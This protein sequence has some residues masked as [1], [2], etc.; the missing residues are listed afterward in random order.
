MPLPVTSFWA[1][2]CSLHPHT[3]KS[4][5][6]PTRPV[7]LCSF[8]FVHQYSSFSLLPGCPLSKKNSIEIGPVIVRKDWMADL[9]GIYLDQSTTA[10]I[11]V[12]R[13]TDWCRALSP[14][15]CSQCFIWISTFSP[16][17]N[18]WDGCYYYPHF[19]D[20]KTAKEECIIAPVS[21][22]SSGRIRIW[23]QVIWLQSQYAEVSLISL[24]S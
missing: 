11:L 8:L 10:W 13:P 20:M 12:R 15:H 18:L 17:S 6:T 7:V 23:T 4:L 19:P 16:F 22:T 1:A 9:G 24:K 21:L 5:L 14:R 3:N 2:L